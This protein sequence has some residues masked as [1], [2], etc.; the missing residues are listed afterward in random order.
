MT[1]FTT[2]LAVLLAAVSAAGTPGLAQTPPPRDLQLY[3]GDLEMPATTGPPPGWAMWGADQFK[4]PHSFTRDTANPH[5][6]TACLRIYHPAKTGGYLVTD[7]AHAIHPQA[8][9]AYTIRFWARSDQAGASSFGFTAYSGIAPYVD[10]PSPGTHRIEVGPQWQLY[11]F[12]IREGRDFFADEDRY[13]LLTF[14]ASTNRSEERTLYV[15]DIKVTETP[16]QEPYP[17]LNLNTI[18]HEALQHCLTPGA[19]L[20]FTV[21]TTRHERSATA[22]AGGVSFHRVAGWTG[23]PYDREGR[24]TLD[25]RLE[26]AMREMRLPMTRFYGVAD[27]SFGLEGALDRLADLC[28]RIGVP[29]QNTVLELEEQSASKAFPPEVWVS[30]IRYCRAKRY[31]FR[32]WEVSNEPYN[33]LWHQGAKSAGQAFPT[34]EAYIAHLKSV[35]AA[36]H[37]EQPDAR[38][39]ANVTTFSVA[40]GN[41]VLR[42][43]AGS[44]DFVAGHYYSTANVNRESFEDLVLTANYQTLDRILRV[45]A[46]LRAYNPQ[47]GVYQ[48]DTEWGMISSGPNG[49]PADDLAR[50]ANIIGAVHR[51]VRMIYY[52]REGMLRGASSWQ[53]LSNVKSPGF[54]ILSQQA[55]DQRFL[56]YWLSYY[57]NRHVGEW[58]LPIAGT[59]P[60]QSDDSH[61]RMGLAPVA[62]GPLTPV[63]ATGSAD[64]RTVY[65]V[66]ANGSWER[67]FPL[68][69]QLHGFSAARA[70]GVVLSQTSLDSS[71]LLEH[72]EDGVSA[73][74]VKLD[75]GALTGTL[76]AHSVAFVTITGKLAR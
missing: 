39:G 34:P 41:R 15:D 47:R 26:Q 17:L 52:A 69:V 3:N 23:Q 64:G 57:F 61:L 20:D 13:L 73:L 35:G 66:L 31:G 18:A 43:A 11:S 60:F 40:W 30:A 38:V 56:L 5:G 76:P 70:E 36:I 50:N 12:T 46:L 8:G 68:R 24:Y 33:G 32:C 74:G 22:M 75:G 1:R 28:T 58:V 7:P 44:Y 51:A 72:K 6:G 65:L 45:N 53:M 29:Q 16:A 71:P 63:M 37:R 62:P 4:D 27:E 14:D 67:S 42:E 55:P 48:L 19:A 25:P 54:G 59:A 9:M 49:E 2:L 10:A 21:D